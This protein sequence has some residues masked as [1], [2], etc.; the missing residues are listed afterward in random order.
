[1]L[2][3]LKDNK[4]EYKKLTEEEMKSRGILGRLVG[5]CADF[6]T[7]TRNNRLYGE[8]LWERV[9]ND[10]LMKERIQNGVCYGELSHPVDRAETDMEKVAVCL[11][12]QPKKGPDGKLRAVFDILSTPNG[13]IL[14]ALCDYGS[15]LGISSRGQGDTLP[16][17]D[18]NECVDPDT[19]SCEGFDVVLIPAVKDARLE[20]VTESLNT[21]KSLQ[22]SLKTLVESADEKDKKVMEE[23]IKDLNLENSGEDVSEVNKID[24]D[25]EKEVADNAG[26]KL[27]SDLQEA[28]KQ[29]KKSQ[30]QIIKLQEQL[31]VGN[32]EGMKMKE[33]LVAYRKL[34]E[35]LS[36]S[37]AILKSEQG[38]GILALRE[39]LKDKDDKLNKAENKLQIAESKLRREKH[40]NE[41][42]QDRLNTIETAMDKSEKRER[43][44]RESFDSRI[45]TSKEENQR[46]HIQLEEQTK[47]FQLKEKQSAKKLHE[48][49]QLVEKYKDTA[50]KAIS[51]YIDLQ[52]N[53]I[54]VKPEEIKN[55]LGETY[56]FAEIDRICEDLRAY[57]ISVNKLPFQLNE[58]ES[59]RIKYKKQTKE[60]ILP[61]N[62]DD[63]IDTSLLSFTNN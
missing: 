53:Q 26:N 32:A 15:K 7:P 47:D 37:L 60:K 13:K 48:S 24:A 4:L 46:L 41:S 27:M 56:S 18:G 8:D 62:D 2:E 52:A 38:Q 16:G 44:L 14:K 28:L 19:Y 11:A 25:D 21:Q 29:N 54:G 33:K 17:D 61:R 12:E 22:E 45:S 9:F 6:I 49:M 51:K 20:Y 63:V 42:L 3:S 55:R 39:S 34:T 36:Q 5:V 10:P 40:I 35:S 31:S 50:R 57:K 43:T 59:P 23:T 1:M 58:S 30:K